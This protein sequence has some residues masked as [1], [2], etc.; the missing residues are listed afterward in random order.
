M[1]N[2]SITNCNTFLS[3]TNVEKVNPIRKKGA[4]WNCLLVGHRGVKK[5]WSQKL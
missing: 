5:M 3:K 2:H 1:K 4:C